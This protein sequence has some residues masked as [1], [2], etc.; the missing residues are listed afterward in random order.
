MQAFGSGEVLFSLLGFRT[1]MDLAG[2]TRRPGRD[3][4]LAMGLGLSW[5]VTLL[6]IDA[7]V[8]PGATALTYV[9]VS[10]RIS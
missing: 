8:S 3:V 4:P 9:G 6:L 1:A 5:M 7:V 10:A 2:E